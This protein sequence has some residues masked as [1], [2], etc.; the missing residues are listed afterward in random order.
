MRKISMLVSVAVLLIV[1]IGAYTGYRFWQK[2]TI[3][4][5]LA[6]VQN[7]LDSYKKQALQYENKQVLQALAAKQTVNDLKSDIVKWSE[8]IK[9]VRD[10]VPKL[11]GEDLVSVLS[12]S[13][14]G[15]NEISMN[16]KTRADS[17]TPYLDI[18]DLI[19]AFDDSGVFED[20]FVASVASGTD[21]SG[22]EI[23]TFNFSA[24]HVEEEPLEGAL[25][26]VLDEALE[27]KSEPVLR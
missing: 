23:L 18:A 3:G 24:K 5:D 2:S 8:V 27:D 16:M 1:L 7:E 11:D 17:K 6:E 20:S 10:T 12:Y 4:K 26:E 14:S 19:E 22:N 21:D 9:N 15:G 25:T 13:G